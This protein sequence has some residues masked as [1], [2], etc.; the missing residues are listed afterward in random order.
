MFTERLGKF[1]RKHIFRPSQILLCFWNVN[2]RR[3]FCVVKSIYYFFST[4]YTQNAHEIRDDF[5]W[6]ISFFFFSRGFFRNIEFPATRQK[7]RKLD[8]ANDKKCW[9]NFGGWRAKTVR[10]GLQR[11]SNHT[12]FFFFLKNTPCFKLCTNVGDK[13]PHTPKRT[14][15]KSSVFVLLCCYL[16]TSQYVCQKCFSKGQRGQ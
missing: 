8:T 3:F 13:S 4:E 2:P 9:K 14:D 11:K 15:T 16:C 6:M 12:F 7:I 1:H 5:R 10:C